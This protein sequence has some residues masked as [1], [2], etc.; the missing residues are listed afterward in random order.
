M[1]KVGRQGARW[2]GSQREM[3]IHRPHSRCVKLK[4]CDRSQDS[5]DGAM[6]PR[7]LRTETGCAYS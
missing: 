6:I 3:T 5:P 7:V 2:A 1:L 4:S